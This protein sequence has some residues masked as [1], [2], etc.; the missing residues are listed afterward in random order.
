MKEGPHNALDYTVITPPT[1]I[2]LEQEML[3]IYTDSQAGRD[4]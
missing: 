3:S 2:D 1:R 4:S